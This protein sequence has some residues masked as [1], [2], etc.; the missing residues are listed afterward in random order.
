MIYN[1]KQ[2]VYPKHNEVGSTVKWLLMEG[3]YAK[4]LA[5]LSKAAV[6]NNSLLV[7]HS[8]SI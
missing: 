5:P 2:L 4:L 6:A 8:F 1:I 3:C 7:M